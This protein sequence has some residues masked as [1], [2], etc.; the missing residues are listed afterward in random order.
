LFS[1]LK[2]IPNKS[3]VQEHAYMYKTKLE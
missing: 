2:N 1:E 3:N